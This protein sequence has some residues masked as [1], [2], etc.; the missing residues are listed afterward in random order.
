[1]RETNN[2]LKIFFGAIMLYSIVSFAIPY[3]FDDLFSYKEYYISEPVYSIPYGEDLNT[4][5]AWESDLYSKVNGSIK[6]GQENI[7]AVKVLFWNAGKKE[8]SAND[9]IQ[10]FQIESPKGTSIVD[11][12]IINRTTNN[13]G[14]TL[15]SKSDANCL[16]INESCLDAKQGFSALIFIQGLSR[17]KLLVSGKTKFIEVKKVQLSDDLPSWGH[18]LYL[19]AALTIIY[20]GYLGI[21]WQFTGV[22]WKIKEGRDPEALKRNLL[23]YSILAIIVYIPRLYKLYYNGYFPPYVLRD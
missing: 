12:K 5:G 19:L 20:F 8:I 1:M 17:E 18:A 23:L 13:N 15:I 21:K 6:T 2:L 11:F 7:N 16:S 3:L 10:D 14:K 4:V 22:T 9:V